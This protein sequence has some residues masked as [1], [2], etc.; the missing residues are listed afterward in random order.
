LALGSIMPARGTVPNCGDFY[1]PWSPMPHPLSIFYCCR[2]FRTTTLALTPGATQLLPLLWTRHGIRSQRGRT[3]RRQG[4]ALR[5]SDAIGRDYRKTFLL[6]P[7]SWGKK[8]TLWQAKATK[9]RRKWV[10]KNGIFRTRYW[11]HPIFMDYCRDMHHLQIFLEWLLLT[12]HCTD[13]YAPSIVQ[14]GNHGEHLEQWGE[15]GELT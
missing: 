15:N 1:V 7:P 8:L 13:T 10:I 11:R 9:W 12:G 4:R 6:N 14:H 5:S 2:M 3:W